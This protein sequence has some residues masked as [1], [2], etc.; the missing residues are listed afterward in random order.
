MTITPAP[1]PGSLKLLLAGLAVVFVCSW[2]R[3]S[4]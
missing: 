2:L 3:K 1:E 4:P